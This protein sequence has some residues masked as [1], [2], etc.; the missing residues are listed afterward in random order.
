MHTSHHTEEFLLPHIEALLAGTLALMTGLAQ[1]GEQCP[2]RDL[3][4]AKVHA[5]LIELSNHP[6]TSDTLRSVLARLIDHWGAMPS[7]GFA[8]GEGM[9]APSVLL[10]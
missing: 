2:H 1:A 8:Q 10:H 5:N 3:M 9:C 6:H 7:P 4:Q